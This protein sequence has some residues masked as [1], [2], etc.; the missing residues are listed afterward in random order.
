MLEIVEKPRP[1]ATCPRLLPFEFIVE[2][3]AVSQQARRRGRWI[4]KIRQEVGRR[5][6]AADPPG[7]PVMVALTYF[8]DDGSPDVDNL[9]KPVLDALNGL[10]FIDD[11]QV[12]DLLVRKRNLSGRLTVDDATP[13]MAAGF[14]LGSPFLHVVVRAAPAQGITSDA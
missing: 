12:T 1:L 4:A 13:I 9:A 6:L 7:G 8:Y 2:G 3:P 14:D 10:V 11:E 5:W